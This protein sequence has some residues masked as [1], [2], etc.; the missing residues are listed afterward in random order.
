MAAN[1]KATKRPPSPIINKQGITLYWSD[2]LGYVT[3]PQD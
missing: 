3:I 2:A 1:K